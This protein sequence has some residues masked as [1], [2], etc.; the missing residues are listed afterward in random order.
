MSKRVSLVHIAEEQL[1]D[2]IRHLPEGIRKLPSEE[3]LCGQL[4]VSRATLRE[5]LGRFNPRARE[6]RDC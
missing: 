5:A 4:D 2:L 3:E 1:L 6:G